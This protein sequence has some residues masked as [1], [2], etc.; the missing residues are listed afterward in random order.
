VINAAEPIRGLGPG[1]LSNPAIPNGF[2]KYT[3]GTFQSPAGDFQV[4]FYKNPT[5][6]EV[7]Y[8]LDYKAV[9]N[10]MSGVPKK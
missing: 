1:K 4:H 8:G 9:F 6:G 7:I 3:T 10:K 2:G 5:T